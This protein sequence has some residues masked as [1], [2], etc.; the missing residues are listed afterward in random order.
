MRETEREPMRCLDERSI[1]VPREGMRQNKSHFTIY[2]ATEIDAFLSIRN[3][4]ERNS[5]ER[6]QLIS[7]ATARDIIK[8]LEMAEFRRSAV[9][10]S[11]CV[12]ASRHSYCSTPCIITPWRPMSVGNRTFF[13]QTMPIFSTVPFKSFAQTN[14]SAGTSSN[15]LDL[16]VSNIRSR[17]QPESSLITFS[18]F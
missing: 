7:I 14:R 11:Q 17:T 13:C 6:N 12:N 9:R 10:S 1:I 15:Q 8:L 16:G 18:L 3:E 4:R 5:N 2:R